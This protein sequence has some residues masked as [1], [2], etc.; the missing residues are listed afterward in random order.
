MYKAKYTLMVGSARGRT[1]TLF[2]PQLQNHS[3]YKKKH[4][5]NERL[6]QD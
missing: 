1:N 5:Q 3:K 2:D 6:T 4:A